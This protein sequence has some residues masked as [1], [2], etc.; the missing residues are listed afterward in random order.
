MS[1]VCRKIKKTILRRWVLCIGDIAWMLLATIG[2]YFLISLWGN[3]T[4]EFSNAV[5]IWALSNTALTIALLWVFRLYNIIYES[6]GFPEAVRIVA[7]T[8]VLSVA[9]VLFAWFAG[10]LLA[11]R[12]IAL[13]A[14][15]AFCLLAFFWL[16]CTRF[17]KR[18]YRALRSLWNNLFTKKK[19]ILVVGYNHNAFTLIRSMA[20]DEKSRY[21]AIGILDDDERYWGKR[22]YDVRRIV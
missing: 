15:V 1:N 21:R 16:A 17:F 14:V 6:V 20:F 3:V 7:T 4:P 5:I 2:S 18:G 11:P 8:A 13:G 10:S 12:R 19:R 9:N 22:I